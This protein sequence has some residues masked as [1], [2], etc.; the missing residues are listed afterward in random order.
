MIM[1]V[2]SH[3][4]DTSDTTFYKYWGGWG[5][6]VFLFLSGYGLFFSLNR[7]PADSTY[8]RRKLA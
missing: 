4:V 5:T 8:L 6:G 2:V 3:V 7:R 1:I